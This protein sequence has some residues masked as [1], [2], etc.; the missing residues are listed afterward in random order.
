MQTPSQR[1]LSLAI[2][3]DIFTHLAAMEKAGLPA[4]KAYSLLKLAPAAQPRLALARKLMA[5]GMNPAS[6][7]DSSGLFTPMEVNLL[8]AAF[9][10]GSPAPVYKRLADTYAYKLKLEKAVKSRMNLPALMLILALFVQPLPRL[11]SGMLSSFAYLRLCLQPLIV[12][13]LLYFLYLQVR[14]WRQHSGATALRLSMDSLLLGLPVFGTMHLRRNARDFFENLGM[15]LEAG[16]PMFEALPKASDA[17]SNYVIRA[18]YEKLLPAMQRGDTLAQA[19]AGIRYA[20][21]RHI[22]GFIQ[23]GEASGSLPE[24][25]ARHSKGE[26]EAIDHFQ[27]QVADWLPR[28]AYSAVAVWMAYGIL[29]TSVFKPPAL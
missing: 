28:L 9:A 20:G 26:S 8:H 13:G 17:V 24:M 15:L 6:A 7:G 11:I 3:A 1:P 16:L 4:D 21:E 5:R 22:V 27:Q 12:I 23:T 10:A 25:L 29:S 18:D 14:G 2:R 19:V